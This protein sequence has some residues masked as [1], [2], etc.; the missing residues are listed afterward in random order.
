M[1]KTDFPVFQHHPDL[2][3]LD[4][5]ATAQKPAAVITVVQEILEKNYGA[6]SRGLYPLSVNATEMY[7]KSRATV[8]EFFQVNR[9][10]IVFTPGAT[11]AF[12]MLAYGLERTLNAGDEIILSVQEHHSNL[13]P[14]QALAERKNLTIHYLPLT[15]AGEIDLEKLPSFLSERTKII[16]VTHCSNVVGTVTNIPRLRKILDEQG[17]T[18]FLIL[19]GCQ[20]APHLPLTLSTLGCDFFIA[21]GHKLYGPS[22]IGVLW[23]RA[24]ALEVLG[25]PFPGGGTVDG[26]QKDRT[27]WKEVPARLEA[28]S[29]NLEGAVGLAAALTYLQG[30]T[31]T[32]VQQE[33]EKLTHLASE[34]LSTIP[35]LKILGTPTPASGIVAFT[36]GTIHPHDVA[37]ILGQHQICIRAGHHCAGPLHEALEIPASCRISLGVYNTEEDIHK[38]Y[39]GLLQIK[40]QFH[41]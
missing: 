8:A 39:E 19:D 14:W 16:S 1:H 35:G 23:G 5:A 12:N 11:A 27:V 25:S 21:S 28:G 30:L 29:L 3:Y 26:V 34:K 18:A 6:I 36:L 41:A 9:Q 40:E 31:M 24:A 20:S 10:E 15:K 33:T 7:E 4:T 37:E 32:T 13:L 17:S 38:L 22:G 2:V